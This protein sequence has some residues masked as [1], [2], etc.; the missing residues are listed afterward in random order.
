M[1]ITDNEL[2][3]FADGELPPA[4][5]AR[6]E[7]AVAVSPELAAKLAGHRALKARLAGHF[8]PVLEQDVPDRLAALLRPSPPVIDLAAARADRANRSRLPRWSWIAGPA[9]AASLLIAVFVPGDRD[10]PAGYADGQLAA[11]LD[12]QVVAD[13]NP[14][15]ATRVLLSFRRQDGDYCRAYAAA[16]TS[17]IA[18]RDDQGWALVEQGAGLSASQSEYEQAGSSMAQLLERA[19]EMAVGG[20]LDAQG[21]Q[22]ARERGWHD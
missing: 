14:Q 11:L 10:S 17:G 5:A 7:A 18:C 2:A 22:A 8:T 20:A 1:S 9:L 21:E 13:Q 6:I 12:R 16:D 15:S 3:A 19:Q 4:E